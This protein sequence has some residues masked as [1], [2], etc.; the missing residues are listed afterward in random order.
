MS[1][2]QHARH[3]ESTCN[4]LGKKEVYSDWVITTAFYASMHFV[5]HLMLPTTVEGTIYN[6]FEEL[7]YHTKAI[8]EGRHGFQKNWVVQNYPQIDYAYSRLHDMSNLARY[9][10]YEYT[11]AQ[12]CIAKGYLDTIKKFVQQEKPE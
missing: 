9:T 5:R 10:K 4:Y 2:I 12:A 6:D 3:N 1:S 11:R 7:F 8:G